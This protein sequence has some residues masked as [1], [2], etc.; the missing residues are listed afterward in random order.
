MYRNS[1]RPVLWAAV[2]FWS[3]T[4]FRDRKTLHCYSIEN[5][6]EM[7]KM[8]RDSSHLLLFGTDFTVIVI[9]IVLQQGF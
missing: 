6:N 4:F 8:V 3:L 1:G 7:Q 2:F 9:T 5:D